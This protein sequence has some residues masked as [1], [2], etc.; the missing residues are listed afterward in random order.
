MADLS[1]EQIEQRYQYIYKRGARFQS[2]ASLKYLEELRDMAL[3]ACEEPRQPISEERIRGY[4]ANV[5][6]NNEGAV[7][8]RALLAIRQAIRE[9]LRS[10]PER[11]QVIEE[12]A[13]IIDAK[14][15]ELAKRSYPPPSILRELSA[16]LR[17]LKGSESGVWVPT[18][19]MEQIESWS[20]AYPT[21][22]FPEPDLA[23]ARELLEAGG[24]SLDSLSASAMRHVITKVWG[25]LSA[26]EGS[27]P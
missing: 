26:Q 3:R 6:L 10:H 24:M 16:A 12:C 9:A 21:D 14:Y 4:A 27:K 25:M 17:Q 7:F 20:K 18:E 13:A 2:D 15:D 19:T 23:K 1:R 5:A 8:D 11:A 22:V